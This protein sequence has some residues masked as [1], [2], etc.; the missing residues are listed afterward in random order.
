MVKIAALPANHLHEGTTLRNIE[1]LSKP[2]AVRM[3]D[4]WFQIAALDHFWICRRFDVFQRL[5]GRLIA[6]AREMAEIGCGNGLLQRQIEE[7][8]GR[9]VTGFD[10]NEFALKQNLSRISKVCC[11]DIYQEDAAL[12]ERFDL[13]FLFDVLEHITDEDRFFK[14]LMFHCA[15]G[16]YAV[17]NVPAGNWAYSAYDEAAGHVRRYSIGTLRAAAGR[18]ALEVTDWSY[19]GLPLVPAL[20]LRKLWLMGNHD[21]GKIISAGFDTRTAAINRMLRFLSRCEPIPQ[22]FLGTS[23]MAVLQPG[24]RSR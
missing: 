11:Y 5:A 6:G 23:L 19:W 3:A 9:E 8:Y 24:H 12:R 20:A 22:K 15:S 16:G 18:N 17:V 10:L 7:A 14:A 13:I 1:Y 21:Q 4:Q 2:A